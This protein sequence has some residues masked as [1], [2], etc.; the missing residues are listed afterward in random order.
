L[1]ESDEED[2]AGGEGSGWGGIGG[3]DDDDDAEA[4][5]DESDDDP[6]K[7]T[8]VAVDEEDDDAGESDEEEENDEDDEDE[9]DEAVDSDDDA[10]SVASSSSS[11]HET[12]AQKDRKDAFFSA[13]P[14]AASSSTAPTAFSSMNLSRPLLRNITNLQF[15]TPTPIQARAIPL[16]L[17]GRDILGAAQTGSGKTAAF[18]IP[19]LERLLYREK[20]R[21]GK[22]AASRVLVLCPT[23]ELA[24]QCEAVGKALSAGMDIRFALLVGGLSLSA[25]A[26]ALKTLPDILIATP[27][28]L[29]DH[30]RNS[31]S[32][33]LD[34]LDILI[35]DEADR[36]L[37]AG[38][39]DELNEIITSCPRGRQTML[40]SATMGDSVDELVR[41]S[42][43]KPVRLF[44]DSTRKT[45][46]NL[47]QE[48]VR[49]R[50]EDMS[51]GGTRAALLLALCRRTVKDKC[52]VFFRSKALAHQMRIVF[53]LCGLG[54]A[55][56]HG[57]LTQEQVRPPG[58]PDRDSALSLMLTPLTCPA[59][60]LLHS[61][62]YASARR[63]QRRQGP[64]PARNRPRLAWSRHQGRRDGDQLRHAWPASSLHS[65]DRS[66]GPC[67][68]HRSLDHARR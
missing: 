5:D 41:L 1:D 42:L 48:F 46:K 23:R 26:Q 43:D 68:P 61:A 20:G 67:R 18:M 16:A 10:V 47:V 62:A 55:E 39:S 54:A 2:A 33:T 3:S 49:V 13:A 9:D 28:R 35:I 65:P 53:G 19:V 59:L 27:G 66:D 40:F 14:E 58:L 32:F 60:V 57:N 50:K 64:I 4:A 30:I 29:I 21:N 34:A 44:V 24:V 51:D 31:Q 8:I 37:E 63:L 45:A 6:M 56:L 38:F 36:M 25:Q 15:A 7:Q 12:Q 17:L 11:T 52:I 22:G